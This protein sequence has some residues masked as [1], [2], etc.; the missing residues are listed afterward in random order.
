MPSSRMR[1][2][3][4][5]TSLTISGAQ[6][7]RRLVQD[8]QPWVQQQGPDDRRHLLLVAQQ[9]LPEIHRA[10]PQARERFM[11]VINCI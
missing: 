3:T 7:L 9:L 2:M 4:R 10:F 8:Q 6:A 1:A 11:D 5:N